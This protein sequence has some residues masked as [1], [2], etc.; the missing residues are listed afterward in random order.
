MAF[1]LALIMVSCVTVVKGGQTVFSA[2]GGAHLP[3]FMPKDNKMIRDNIDPMVDQAE[4]TNAIE[5]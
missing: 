3:Y 4:Q 5:G 1:A 2:A